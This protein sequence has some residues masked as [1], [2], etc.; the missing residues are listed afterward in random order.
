M[1][2][3]RIVRVDDGKRHMSFRLKIEEKYVEIRTEKSI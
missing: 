2:H 1:K 3:V